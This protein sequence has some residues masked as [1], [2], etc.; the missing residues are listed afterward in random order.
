MQKEECR[1]QKEGKRTWLGELTNLH[2]EAYVSTVH[3]RKLLQG[4]HLGYSSSRSFQSVMSLLLSLSRS[5]IGQ[6][7]ERCILHS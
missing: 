6:Q 4:K 1:M 2:D 5:S 3:L 7:N